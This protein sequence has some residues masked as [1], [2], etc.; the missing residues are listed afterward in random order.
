MITGNFLFTDGVFFCRAFSAKEE[1][2]D[3]V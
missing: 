3:G 2:V 1:K